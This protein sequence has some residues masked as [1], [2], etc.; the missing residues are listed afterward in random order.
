M[1]SG[2]NKSCR[3][4]GVGSIRLRMYDEVDMIMPQVRYVLEFEIKN[5]MS[6]GTLESNECSFKPENG[7]MRILE[8][9][10]QAMKVVRRNSL[11]F[12]L[13]STVV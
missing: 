7:N 1:I 2:N 9:S 11:Y 12:L 3:V 10:L 4:K 13:E 8:G 6:L 5:L